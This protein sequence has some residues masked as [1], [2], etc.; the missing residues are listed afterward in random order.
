MN[1]KLGEG[2]EEIRAQRN[3]CPEAGLGLLV[4]PPDVLVLDGE[5]AKALRILHQKRLVLI[6]CL[7]ADAGGPLMIGQQS[8]RH[9]CSD[10]VRM[11]C[12]VVG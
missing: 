9:D 12:R 4:H 6:G 7:A 11:G 10:G 2:E 1:N 8:R 5:H 3:T